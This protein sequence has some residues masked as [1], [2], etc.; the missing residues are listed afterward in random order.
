MNITVPRGTDDVD[1]ASNAW[2]LFFILFLFHRVGL[3]NWL[4]LFL[5]LL[6]FY[7][8]ALRIVF[9]YI[10]DL[11][12]VFATLSLISPV[13]MYSTSRPLRCS[14]GGQGVVFGVIGTVIVV[15]FCG[16]RGSLVSV[17]VLVG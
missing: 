14:A 11:F 10:T 2:L 17:N 7:F 12:G 3:H 16:G 6:L 13:F 1:G 9:F 15:V 5:F 8:L 4:F